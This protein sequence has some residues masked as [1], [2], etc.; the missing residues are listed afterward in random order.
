MTKDIKLY[1]G[2][3]KKPKWEEYCKERGLEEARCSLKACNR[4]ELTKGEKVIAVKR[5]TKNSFYTI[6]ILYGV[7][8]GKIVRRELRLTSSENEAI[9]ERAKIDG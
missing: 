8:T 7:D 2:K 1:L 6:G 5:K 4:K 9:L 3:L